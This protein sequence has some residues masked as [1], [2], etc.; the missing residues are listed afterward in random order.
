MARLIKPFYRFAQNIQRAKARILVIG[1]ILIM[2]LIVILG[3]IF[4]LRFSY[5]PVVKQYQAGIGKTLKRVA[6]DFEGINGKTAFSNINTPE[7]INGNISLFRLPIDYINYLPGHI[8]DL[9]PIDACT[10]AYKNQRNSSICAGMLENPN[11]GSMAYIQG[12]FDLHEDI[13]P[14]VY[15]SSPKS[16]HHFLLSVDARGVKQDFVVTFDKLVRSNDKVNRALPSAWSMTGFKYLGNKQVAYVREPDIKGRILR[17][18]KGKEHY[19]YIFQV[20]IQVYTG[21]ALSSNKA[22]PPTDME[23]AKIS[24]KLISP[25]NGAYGKIITDTADLVTVPLFSFNGMAVHLSAGETL[26][27]IPLSENRESA[28]K[29]NSFKSESSNLHRSTQ[30]KIFERVSDILIRAVLPSIS[31]EKVFNL[32]DGNVIKFNG[33]ASLVFTGWR[34]AAQAIIVFA[35]L[36]CTSLVMAGI[37]L[38][39]Y[40]LAPLNNLRRNTL[41]LSNKFSD[42][43]NFKLPYTLNNRSDEIGVLWASILDM[44]RSITSYGREALENTKRQADFLRALGHEIKS[45]LQDLTIRHS[46]PSDPSFKIIKRITHALKILSTTPASMSSHNPYATTPKE[47]I[48]ASRA[49]LTH[50]NVTEY[51]NN[52]EEAYPNVKHSERDRMLKVIADADFLEAA[53]TAILNNAQDFQTPDTTI[54]ITSYSDADWV[55]ISIFNIG[56]HITKNPIDEIF[57][58]GVSC[59]SGDNDHQGMGLYLAKQ[60]IINMGGDLTVKNVDSGVRF[61]IKLVR[62]K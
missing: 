39:H 54:T 22:W 58:F 53:L 51:L 38:N 11:N 17:S 32:T 1:T 34:S 27:F 7:P 23:S 52:A 48:S 49:N 40:L 29:I 36:L 5:A 57:E 44:H 59:R 13:S 43:D 16:G 50:E 9:K 25:V 12:S 55:L 6:T 60:Y 56:P 18:N 20:P 45:P 4:V 35:L 33:N 19:E 61:D 26:T 30:R 8:E 62:V 10:Y 41:Y 28:V 24:L 47:A 21:D 46:D 3:T 2:I 37:V 42:S 15:A 14:P 31:T